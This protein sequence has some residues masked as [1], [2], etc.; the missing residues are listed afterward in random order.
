MTNYTKEK[1]KPCDKC[2]NP[3]LF[4]LGNGKDSYAVSIDAILA[5]LKI[6]EDQGAVPELENDWWIRVINRYSD[7]KELLNLYQSNDESHDKLYS[8]LHHA[9]ID[10]IHRLLINNYLIKTAITNDF[11]AKALERLKIIRCPDNITRIEHQKNID[12]IISLFEMMAPHEIDFYW[13]F[14][15]ER[16]N[17]DFAID[18]YYIILTMLSCLVTSVLLN[19]HSDKY[20][21]S[22]FEDLYEELEDKMDEKTN[23]LQL[24]VNI[25]KVT[26]YF[27][28]IC[29]YL[30]I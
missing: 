29:S 15:E 22:K 7:V 25:D 28:R 13:I 6:A 21:L 1:I 27:E 23:S 12:Q 3:I 5:C 17:N 20:C 11:S 9:C 2:E 30:Q 24:C 4:E 19:K 10:I 8:K 18:L 16:Y 26:D 14:L